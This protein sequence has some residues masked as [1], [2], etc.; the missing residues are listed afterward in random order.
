[1]GKEVN[2]EVL[3]KLSQEL[4]S[5]KFP[6]RALGLSEAE[7]DQIYRDNQETKEQCF[8]M[9]RRWKDKY[10]QTATY[11]VLS[12]ALV[13]MA[14]GVYSFFVQIVLSHVS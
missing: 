3:L 12:T 9:L 1:M 4:T 6:A 7:I 5:W 10:G 2:S 13:A 11:Q 14:R 8:Q